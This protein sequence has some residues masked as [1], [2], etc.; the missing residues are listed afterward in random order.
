MDWLNEGDLDSHVL[1][2][3]AM[4]RLNLV[5]IHPWSD[6]NGRMSRSLQMLLIARGVVL[7]PTARRFIWILFYVGDHANK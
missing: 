3:A 2:R 7:P 5:K 4:A 1:I 6:G